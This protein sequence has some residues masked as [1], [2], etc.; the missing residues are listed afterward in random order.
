M[1]CRKYLEKGKNILIVNNSKNMNFAQITESL[2]R[3][4]IFAR[5]VGVNIKALKNKIISS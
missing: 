1:I 2:L 3:K 4:R 5:E